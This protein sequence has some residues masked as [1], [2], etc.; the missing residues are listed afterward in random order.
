[1]GRLRVG[2]PDLWYKL[3]R[4]Y[5][6]YSKGGPMWI[7]DGAD[8]ERVFRSDNPNFAFSYSRSL[9]TDVIGPYHG[10]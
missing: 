8:G 5:R 4:G 2:L 1:V 9:W 7:P 10:L 6:D 3:D